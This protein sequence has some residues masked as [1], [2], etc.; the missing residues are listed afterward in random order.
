MSRCRY[1]VMSSCWRDDPG[2]RPA[3][4]QLLPVLKGLLA[5][6]PQLEADQEVG[7]IN[8]VPEASAGPD[9]RRPSPGPPERRENAYMPCPA[10]ATPPA[11]SS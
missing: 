6:L 4:S 8:Q 7:Y 10:A 3:F 2:S 11:L 1:E 5:E 9:A